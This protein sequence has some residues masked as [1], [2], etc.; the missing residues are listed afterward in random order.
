MRK[1]H[2]YHMYFLKDLAKQAMPSV[3]GMLTLHI[4]FKI[5]FS[6]THR[7]SHQNTLYKPR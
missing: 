1:F 2:T 6:N 4:K 3:T 7:K 5:S